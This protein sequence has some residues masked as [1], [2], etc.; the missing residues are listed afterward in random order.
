MCVRD[1][2][3]HLFEV[4]CLRVLRL[5]VLELLGLLS[6]DLLV[7]ERRAVFVDRDVQ[8]L[9]DESLQS[10]RHVVRADDEDIL[11]EAAIDLVPVRGGLVAQDFRP[12]AL[13]PRGPAALGEPEAEVTQDE[14]DLVAERLV[15]VE[16]APFDAHEAEDDLRDLLVHLG[17]EHLAVEICGFS[18]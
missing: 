16:V 5:E 14:A 11:V 12:I 4:L 7:E 3:R 6:D 1:G 9:G 2:A 10:I 8:A 15:P 13:I 18:S 17:L